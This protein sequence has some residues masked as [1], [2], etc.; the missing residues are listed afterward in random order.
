[1]GG[2]LLKR[3]PRSQGLIARVIIWVCLFIPL[4]SVLLPVKAKLVAVHPGTAVGSVLFAS[5]VAQEI[6][7]HAS[8]DQ[9]TV[10][11]LQ[12]TGDAVLFAVHRRPLAVLVDV[13]EENSFHLHQLL[14]AD[15]GWL[16]DDSPLQ[17]LEHKEKIRNW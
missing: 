9:P 11:G 10:V 16:I 2:A 8:V 7:A 14:P 12:R 13:I 4:V 1:M 6:A 3:S 17:E 15:E 5:F